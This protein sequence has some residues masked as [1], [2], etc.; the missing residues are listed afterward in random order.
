MSRWSI[1]AGVLAVVTG[2]LYFLN[3]INVRISYILVQA[4]CAIA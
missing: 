4:L 1:G 3:S 2:L